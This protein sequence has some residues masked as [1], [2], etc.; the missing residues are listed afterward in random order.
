VQF[1]ADRSFSINEK[2]QATARSETA[3]DEM[4]ADTFHHSTAQFVQFGESK[5]PTKK[6]PIIDVHH[7]RLTR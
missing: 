4:G 3:M 6:K 7:V 1:H 2:S 5:E